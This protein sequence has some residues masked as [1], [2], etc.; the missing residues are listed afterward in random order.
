[1]FVNNKIGHPGKLIGICI[2]DFVLISSKSL[3]AVLIRQSSSSKEPPAFIWSE[4]M[5]I[6]VKDRRQDMVTEKNYVI[7]DL[8]R[9]AEI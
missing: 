5:F 2:A 1:M 4:D 9:G 3:H 8:K 7:Y 6:T